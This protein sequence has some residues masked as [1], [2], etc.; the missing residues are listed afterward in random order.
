MKL[1]NKI[2][3]RYDEITFSPKCFL[4][5]DTSKT[6][7]ITMRIYA[8]NTY[9]PKPDERQYTITRYIEKITAS[10]S[11]RTIPYKK[12]ISITG[13]INCILKLIPIRI[14]HEITVMT[15]K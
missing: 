8:Y 4:R 11:S 3:T 14:I 12:A 9:I 6:P 10:I 5:Y 1:S 15:N 2:T 7:K 13:A